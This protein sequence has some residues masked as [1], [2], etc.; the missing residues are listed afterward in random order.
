MTLIS[1]TMTETI[2]TARH[3]LGFLPLDH[4]LDLAKTNVIPDPF[5][6]MISDHV[7]IGSGN[8]FM[9]GVRI[10]AT[11]DAPCIIGDNNRFQTSLVIE[12]ATGPVNIGN[13][14]LVT[15]GM[16]IMRTNGPDATITIRDHVRIAGHVQ[17]FGASYLGTG[18]QVLGTITALSC[19]LGDGA[20]YTDPDPDQRGAVL[21]GSG[22][23]RNLHIGMG[24]VMNG[25]GHFDVPL[26]RQ[27]HYH[28]KPG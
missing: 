23:A 3:K 25:Q 6:V 27:S 10:S 18:S 16:V 2:N 9:P 4:V 11:A 21:K 17:L 26:E 1:E 8:V 7:T 15:D 22:Q 12:A 5:S 14:I 24:E 13:D 20:A 28:P 19:H